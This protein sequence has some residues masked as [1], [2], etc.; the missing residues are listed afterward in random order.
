MFMG[1]FL[2]ILL[3]IYVVYANSLLHV[4]SSFLLLYF[5]ILHHFLYTEDK[6]ISY[7]NNNN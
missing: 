6:N 2:H 3:L 4:N 1:M 5:Q 7:D